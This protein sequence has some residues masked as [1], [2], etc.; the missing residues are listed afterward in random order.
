MISLN[1]Q[2]NTKWYVPEAFLSPFVDAIVMAQT[3]ARR[4]AIPPHFK[5]CEYVTSSERSE[6]IKSITELDSG[7]VADIKDCRGQNRGR[8]VTLLM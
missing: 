4:Y 3:L 6:R 1:F 7:H 8:T 5:P 2:L